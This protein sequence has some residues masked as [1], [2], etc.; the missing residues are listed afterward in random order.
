MKVVL[1]LRYENRGESEGVPSTAIREICLLKGLHH[2]CIVELL[3]IIFTEEK[4]LH[5]VFEYLD[6]DLKRYM[7]LNKKRLDE[8]IIKVS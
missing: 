8:N 7:D 4:V 2:A 6:M 1:C 3:D 5:I